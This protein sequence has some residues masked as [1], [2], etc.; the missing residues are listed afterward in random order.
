[1]PNINFKPGYGTNV[2]MKTDK[3]RDSFYNGSYANAFKL[4]GLD[5]EAK[6][7]NRNTYK[8]LQKQ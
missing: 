5:V 8:S 2:P 1:L 6:L 7:Q 4:E 3:N